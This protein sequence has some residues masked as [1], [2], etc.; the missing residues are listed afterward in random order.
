M[1]KQ[2]TKFPFRII[3]LTIVMGA[4]VSILFATF[5]G[6]PKTASSMASIP[7]D[8]SDADLHSFW[9]THMKTLVAD[10]WSK[11]KLP[12]PELNSR[13]TQLAT[14][15]YQRYGKPFDVELVTSYHWASK[16]VGAA[17]GINTNGAADVSFF[18]SAF[19]DSY[20]EIQTSTVPEWPRMWESHVLIIAMHEMEHAAYPSKDT[21]AIDA[22]EESR[23]WTE[24]MRYTVVPLVETYKMPLAPTELKFYLA[25][26]ASQGNAESPIWKQSIMSSYGAIDGRKMPEK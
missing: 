24:T 7:T 4:V 5:D 10:Q 6:R 15:V 1:K 13:Y 17:A 2:K 26:K 16:R 3:I 23:A 12:Y 21:K 25:W 18:I 8:Y 20:K 22:E 9:D 14:Q 11:A 19:L